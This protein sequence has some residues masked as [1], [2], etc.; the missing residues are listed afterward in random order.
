MDVSGTQKNDTSHL[1]HDS[2]YGDECSKLDLK[3]QLETRER[4]KRESRALEFK[5]RILRRAS[6]VSNRQHDHQLRLIRQDLSDLHTKTPSV[7]I[8]AAQRRVLPPRRSTPIRTK[9]QQE[10]LLDFIPT[11]DGRRCSEVL[12]PITEKEKFRRHTLPNGFG[13]CERT[14]FHTKN[15]VRRTKC[16]TNSLD[17]IYQRR[18]SY[19]VGDMPGSRK[20]VFRIKFHVVIIPEND[21]SNNN[22][23]KNNN[24]KNILKTHSVYYHVLG[25]PNS[26][27]G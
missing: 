9:R 19:D 26:S 18:T 8:L 14:N 1:F 20:C 6:E 22:N 25:A 12:P 5:S 23:N 16:I 15:I 10:A 3:E 17:R 11:G 27:V 24:N 2:I 21:P 13:A 4:N 7:E